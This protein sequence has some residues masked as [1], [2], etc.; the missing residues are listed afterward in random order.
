M[1]KIKVKDFLYN[2]TVE[3]QDRCRKRKENEAR[4]D[5]RPK[6]IFK[7]YT[8]DVEH[9]IADALGLTPWGSDF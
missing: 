2:I 7:H 9:E 6:K 8:E 1:A 3:E 5:N 4:L